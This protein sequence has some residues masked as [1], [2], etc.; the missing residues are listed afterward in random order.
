MSPNASGTSRFF[1]SSNVFTLSVHVLHHAI[2]KGVLPKEQT[3]DR[4]AFCVEPPSPGKE[5]A[6]WNKDS[7]ETIRAFCSLYLASSNVLYGIV[8]ES[9][10]D[11][12][13]Q[14]YLSLR[15][16]HP[17]DPKELHGIQAHAYFRVGMMCAIACA[18]KARYR[19]EL[20]AKSL[21]YYEN[22][23]PYVEEVTSEAS[24]A[25]LQALLLLVVFCLFWPRK[26]E[27]WKLL[28]YACRL[29]VELGYHTEQPIE[30][31]TEE[32]K[33][34]RRSSFWGLYAIERI[35]GQL[36]GRGADLPEPIIT[37]EYPSV[38]ITTEGVDQASLQPMSIGHHYR[39]VYLRSEI[40]RECYMP[41]QA[42]EFDLSWYKERYTLLSNWRKELN[43]SESKA[44]VA[45]VTC[46]VGYD[47]TICFIF[48]PLM[49]RAISATEVTSTTE[50]LI[51][52]V[53][54]DN[55]WSS[56]GLIRSYE[57]II[58]APEDSPLG[59]YPMTF[60]SA[61][62]IYLAGLTLMTHALLALDGKVRTLKK[63]S[64]LG[65]ESET[66]AIDFSELFEV[67]NSCLIILSWCAE[68]WPG[69]EGMMD[70]YKKLA[71]KVIPAMFRKGLL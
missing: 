50:I 45:T 4:R 43:V 31:E 22:V 23:L 37:T 3:T 42:Q 29:S 60:M 69:M 26:G 21:I 20:A 70:V 5:Q 12:D 10:A 13:I 51:K 1:G 33:R 54:Q 57:K 48:Q 35:I 16:N 47:S 38:L 66:E 11:A 34:L 36:F 44:G 9:A 68:R 41:A 32:Q 6:G 40:F 27:I 62:Y 2:R 61:H 49:L 71:D 25:S 46:D 52:S 59:T 14:V 53:P 39:L 17:V 7:V 56:Y 55:Y 8:D 30:H 64:E 19:P 63:F 15:G 67:S 24:P 65:S 58:R 28:D 18:T